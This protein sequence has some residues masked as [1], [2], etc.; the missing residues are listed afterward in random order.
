MKKFVF[1]VLLII[2]GI[3]GEVKCAVK[4]IKCNWEPIGKAEVVYTV[5]FF[6]GFGSIVGWFDVIDK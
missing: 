1:V 5:A 6:T 3:I 2:L 4:A